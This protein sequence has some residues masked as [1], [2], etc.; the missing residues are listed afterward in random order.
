MQRSIAEE[1]AG[2]LTWKFN[3]LVNFSE[4]EMQDL[5]DELKRSD[6]GEKAAKD[7][8]KLSI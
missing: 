3:R 8:T 1:K 4:E 7:D 5:N 2:Q 6:Q